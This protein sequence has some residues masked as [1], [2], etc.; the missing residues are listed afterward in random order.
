VRHLQMLTSQAFESESYDQQ[1]ENYQG[2]AT[3]HGTENPRVWF[4]D[5]L[6]FRGY[7]ARPLE[8]WCKGT[9]LEPPPDAAVPLLLKVLRD[10]EWYLQRNA[11]FLLNLRIEAKARREISYASAPDEIETAIRQYHDWWA[12]YVKAKEAKEK[13]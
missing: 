9:A 3:A 4:R 12:A 10:K 13:G 6:E 1:A 5:S 11:S 8:D 2:W 7:D